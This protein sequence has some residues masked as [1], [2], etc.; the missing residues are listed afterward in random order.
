MEIV[1]AV[2]DANNVDGRLLVFD[3]KGERLYDQ[4]FKYSLWLGGIADFGNDK[5]LEIVTTSSE[6]FLNIYNFKLETIR[7]YKVGGYIQ[8]AVKGISDMDG[9][10]SR[11]IIVVGWDGGVAVLDSGLKEKWNEFVENFA[12]KLKSDHFLVR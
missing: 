12:E 3:S 1:G 8:S 11:E 5:D 10:G 4:E 6:G 2:S 7:T 9:D